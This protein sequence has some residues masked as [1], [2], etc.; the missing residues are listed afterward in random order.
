MTIIMPLPFPFR[1][2]FLPTSLLPLYILLTATKDQLAC[3]TAIV[4]IEFGL[5]FVNFLAI[6]LGVPLSLILL[7]S[8][9]S[10]ANNA[11]KFLIILTSVC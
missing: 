5:F 6:V 7:C 2:S 3:S 8:K 1:I 4:N 11:F 10:K 9:S